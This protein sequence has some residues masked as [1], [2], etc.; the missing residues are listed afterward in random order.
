MTG[1]AS[2]DGVGELIVRIIVHT[3]GKHNVVSSL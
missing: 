1:S 3:A 2:R